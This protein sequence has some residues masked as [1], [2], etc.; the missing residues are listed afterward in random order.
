M[1]DLFG[2]VF[3]AV[4]TQPLL[5]CSVAGPLCEEQPLYL[6]NPYRVCCSRCARHWYRRVS[7]HEWLAV[8]H[9]TAVGRYQHWLN[10]EAEISRLLA[11]CRIP[12]SKFGAYHR[13]FLQ[14]GE[15][16]SLQ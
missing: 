13:F 6:V 8:E 7:Q 4:I 15:Y 3:V 1:A 11:A 12:R 16:P 5:R 14:H 10:R 2:I 9:S